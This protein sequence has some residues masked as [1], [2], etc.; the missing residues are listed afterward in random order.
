[1]LLAPH[2]ATCARRPRRPKPWSAHAPVAIRSYEEP[3]SDQRPGWRTAVS[4]KRPILALGSG[5]SIVRP[6]ER[7]SSAQ[8]TGA[9][10]DIDE[11]AGSA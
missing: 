5:H 3:A 10:T 1:M 11:C 9:S 7:P 2:Q 6:T 4:S 8:P